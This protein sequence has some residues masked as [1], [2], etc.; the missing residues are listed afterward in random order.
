[1]L[2]PDLFYLV[3][4]TLRASIARSNR[5]KL[6]VTANLKY[7][8]ILCRRS[9]EIATTCEWMLALAHYMLYVLVQPRINW[10]VGCRHK[11]M[12]LPSY[13]SQQYSCSLWKGDVIS[14]VFITLFSIFSFTRW[15]YDQT[16]L[17][18]YYIKKKIKNLKINVLSFWFI[19]RQTKYFKLCCRYREVSKGIHKL[20]KYGQS[21]LSYS[22]EPLCSV[23]QQ[24]AAVCILI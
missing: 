21:E 8:F 10:G 1:M 16:I 23:L 13:Y 14:V 20:P 12:T 7:I 6:P 17:N 5:G 11:V 9:K 22:S 2:V 4:E 15:A 24:Q 3:F 18:P 19:F